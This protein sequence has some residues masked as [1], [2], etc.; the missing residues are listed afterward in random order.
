MLIDINSFNMTYLLLTIGLLGL[1]LVY[2]FVQD[3]K[4][5]LDIFKKFDDL[6]ITYDD[7]PNFHDRVALYIVRNF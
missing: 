7:C 6:R 4:R 1:V 2:G 3:V 5:T